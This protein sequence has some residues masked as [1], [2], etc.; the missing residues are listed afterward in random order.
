[1]RQVARRFKVALATVRL[2]VSRAAGRRLDRVDWADRPDGP[3][4]PANRTPL[5]VEDLVLSTRAE[6]KGFSDL[7]EFG[8]RAIHDA[9]VARGERAVPSVRTIGR[10]LERRGALDGRRRVRRPAPP[11][12]WYLPAVAARRAELDS[13]DIVEGLVIRGGTAVEHPHG[14]RFRE[15]A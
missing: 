7:G 2:W 9:L 12:G 15:P 10:I 4:R 3:R 11:P 1:M 14:G 6:L 5:E 13:F 8:A